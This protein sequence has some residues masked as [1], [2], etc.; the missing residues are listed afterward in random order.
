[1]SK[2]NGQIETKKPMQKRSLETRQ[3]LIESGFHIIAKN[4]FHSTT[5]DEIAGEAGLSTGIAYRYF[6]NKKDLMLEII[7]HYFSNI[8]VF[9]NT[10]HNKLSGYK[11]VEDAISYVLDQFYKIHET[12]YGIHEE[13]E[14]MRH[15]D[16]DIKNAYDAIL[17][18]AVDEIVESFLTEIKGEDHLKEKVYYGL[19]VL[20]MYS[21]M[22]MDDFY[23]DLDM[24]C[25]KNLAIKDV[26]R[27]LN[28]KEDGK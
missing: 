6:K 24:E 5:M 21:H 20:E 26:C 28:R 8:Q 18:Q 9:S 17:K 7:E 25:I 16:Q 27:L 12:Y 11:S 13:L 14:G 22:A 23:K 2:D 1:M 19:S 4:G 3:K 15:T 10:N